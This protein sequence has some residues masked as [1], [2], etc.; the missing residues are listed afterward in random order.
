MDDFN[1]RLLKRLHDLVTVRGVG[2]FRPMEI[3]PGSVGDQ[4]HAGR[5]GRTE[6]HFLRQRAEVLGFGWTV[7]DYRSG[8]GFVV[9]PRTMPTT[10]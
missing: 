10:K 8:C 3:F 7:Q 5:V 6:L 2:D 9:V 4:L 1:Y